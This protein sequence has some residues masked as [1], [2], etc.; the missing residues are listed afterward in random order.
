LEAYVGGVLE[1]VGDQ[2][3][4]GLDTTPWGGEGIEISSELKDSSRRRPA[5]ELSSDISRIPIPG[6]K[7]AALKERQ[8][9]YRLK[10]FFKSHRINMPCMATKCN[11]PY[12]V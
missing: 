6:Q 10:E 7:E 3:W 9:P 12:F 4:V 8:V 2:E 1:L 5:R 11:D